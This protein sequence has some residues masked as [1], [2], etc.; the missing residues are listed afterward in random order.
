MNKTRETVSQ[1]LD[2]LSR[3][4]PGERY[5]RLID[6]LNSQDQSKVDAARAFLKKLAN[7]DVDV[8]YVL[9]ISFKYDTGLPFKMDFNK[10]RSAT[11]ANHAGFCGLRDDTVTAEINNNERG[12]C[13]SNQAESQRGNEKSSRGAAWNFCQDSGATRS[14]RPSGQVGVFRSWH[15]AYSIRYP[16]AFFAPRSDEYFSIQKPEADAKAAA[17]AAI[18]N[19]HK[20]REDEVIGAFATRS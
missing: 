16:N 6:D 14:N 12:K 15:T 3:T 8:P 18:I 5:L 9:S 4:V 1:S 17:Y 13:G 10:I 11:S 7:I 2:M 19:N 20:Q